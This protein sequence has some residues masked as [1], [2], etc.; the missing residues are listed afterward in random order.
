MPN[1]Y[2]NRTRIHF[3][4]IGSGHPVLLIPDLG[5]DGWFWH[6]VAPALG[7]RYQVI[8]PD[9]RGTGQSAK[10]EGPYSVAM[11]A[12]DMAGLIDSLQC[13][14]AFVVG[15]GLGAYVAQH[16]ALERP[17]L[18]AKLVLAAG[19][20]GGPTAVP[21]ADEATDLQAVREG[22]SMELIERSVNQATAPGFAQRKPQVVRQIVAYRMGEAVAAAEYDA[23][24]EA[25]QAMAESEES[26]EDLLPQLRMPTLILAGEQDSVVPPANA[27][28]LAARIPNATIVTLPDAG[29]L[30]PLEDPEATVA[31]LV[32]FLGGRKYPD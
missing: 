26:F 11:L 19:D 24:L 20:Y 7:E 22:D 16:L 1:A 30:F 18:V 21:G 31:A 5:Y 32:Q 10:P 13:R 14:G 28:L 6:D 2:T 29:H 25:L 8:V 27:E 3:E 23:H 12:E 4:S 17:E 9:P 15:H